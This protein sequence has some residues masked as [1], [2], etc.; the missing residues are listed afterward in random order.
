MIF[1]IYPFTDAKNIKIVTGKK[2]QNGLQPIGIRLKG[3][4]NSLTLWSLDDP[5][6]IL[7][8]ALALLDK[9]FGEK[10][11]RITYGPPTPL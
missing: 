6:E 7:S 5:R 9:H 10:T 1:S 2:Y 8:K 11:V 3:N 4:G